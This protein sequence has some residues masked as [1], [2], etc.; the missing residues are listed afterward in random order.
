MNAIEHG[1][2]NRAEVPVRV[3]VDRRTHDAVVVAITDQGGLARARRRRA[4]ALPDLDA[5]LAGL[6]S[7]RGWG[8]FLI[9][10]MVDEMTVSTDGSDHTIELTMHLAEDPGS[11]ALRRM[12]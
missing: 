6:Q 7:P 4:P 10:N 3:R 5:K 11:R 9:K 1:N 12:A 2:R 8:L